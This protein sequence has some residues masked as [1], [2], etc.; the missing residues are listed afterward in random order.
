MS[1]T[2]S[3]CTIC[4]SDHGRPLNILHSSSLGLTD[5]SMRHGVD[6]RNPS[7]LSGME[8][9]HPLSTSWWLVT[10]EVKVTLLTTRTLSKTWPNR[11]EILQPVWDHNSLSVWGTT[12]MIME[13]L[14]W[15]TL[16]LKLHLRYARLHVRQASQYQ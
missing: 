5:V 13:S 9:L 1:C 12:S 14:M 7:L 8:Q 15:M 6:Q 11:W 3:V 16:A 2:I 10:G 4:R